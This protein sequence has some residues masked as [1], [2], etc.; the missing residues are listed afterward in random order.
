MAR[1]PRF[2]PRRLDVR[3]FAQAAAQLQGQ[4]PQSELPRLAES[5][6]ARPGDQAAPAASWSATGALRPVAG[7]APEV[8]LH[9][10][11]S[12]EVTLQC[13]RCLHPMTEALAVDRRF[14]FAATPEEA[15]RLDEEIEDDVLVTSRAFDLLALVEDELILALP[16]VPRHDVCPKPLPMSAGEIDAAGGDPAEHP[17]AALRR[18]RPTGGKGEEE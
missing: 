15:E 9:L 13:Q 12:A 18:L 5:V 3:A 16:L 1:T 10:E 14:L 17:F 4:T 11:A 2:D 6:L 7:A 8:W